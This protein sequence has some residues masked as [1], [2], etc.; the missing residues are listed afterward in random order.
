MKAEAKEREHERGLNFTCC[1]LITEA[2]VSNLNT[3]EADTERLKVWG[4]PGTYDKS[5]S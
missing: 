5:P 1:K 3:K 2:D 4:Q